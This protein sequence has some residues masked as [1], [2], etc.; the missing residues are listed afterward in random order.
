MT[1]KY[2]PGPWR[3][4]GTRIAN[5]SRVLIAAVCGA[6]GDDNT[7][8]ANARLIAAAP[9]LLAAL[10]ELLA[11]HDEGREDLSDLWPKQAS[12][13]RAAIARAVGEA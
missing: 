10:R 4:T 11:K 6:S 13:A 12:V 2:T 5:E 7:E 8:A 3:T 1:T 9:D